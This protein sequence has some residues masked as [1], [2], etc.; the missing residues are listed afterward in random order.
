MASYK[1]AR[2]AEDLKREISAIIRE[3]KDD[4][5]TTMLS[6][7]KVVVAGDLSFAKV[8]VSDIGGKETTEKAVEGLT[9]ATGYIRKN[10]ADRLHLRKAPDLRF[11]LDDSLE[12]SSHINSIL[13][14]INRG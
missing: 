4:R 2:M 12:Y 9:H 10:L 11:I 8:Y 5:I 1:T 3:L 14:K 6:V 7:I 13:D